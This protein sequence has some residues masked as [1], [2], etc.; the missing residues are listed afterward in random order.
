MEGK[1]A[2]LGIEF[3]HVTLSNSLSPSDSW[4]FLV[5][6]E[7]IFLCGHYKKVSEMTYDKT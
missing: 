3:F 5:K 7:K 6:S 1:S 2:G 4:A